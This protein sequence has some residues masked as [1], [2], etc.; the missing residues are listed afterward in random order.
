M[1]TTSQPL[2]GFGPG[3]VLPGEVLAGKY[4]VERVLGA[5][6]WG[7]VLAARN[8]Q[9]GQRVAIKLLSREKTPDARARM[10]REAQA[11][12]RIHSDHVVQVYDVGCTE[13][14]TPYIVMEYLEGQDLA[15][16]LR[17]SGAVPVALAVH[18]VL[19]ACEGLAAA[20]RHG[21]VHRDLKPA[22][23]FLERRLDGSV[24]LKLL[25]FGIA[26]MPDTA[27]L[28]E[29]GGFMGSPAYMAPEQL[30]DP[31]DVDVRTDVWGLG[32][33][34]YELLT[35]Q[36]PFIAEAPLA[37][38]TKLR[39]QPH[40]PLRSLCSDVPEAL[41]R[42]VDRCLAKSREARWQGVGPLAR[43]L[44]PFAPPQAEELIRGIERVSAGSNDQLTLGGEAPVVSRSVPGRV[45]ERAAR[46]AESDTEPSGLAAT[47]AGPR[48]LRSRLLFATLVLAALV[49]AFGALWW[50]RQVSVAAPVALSAS[51]ASPLSAAAVS[52]VAVPSVAAPAAATSTMAPTGAPELVPRKAGPHEPEAPAPEPAR[53]QRKVSSGRAVAPP[54]RAAVTAPAA[55]GSN[56]ARGATSPGAAAPPLGEGSSKTSEPPARGPLPI[57]RRGPW[58]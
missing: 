40:L 8:L 2:A 33:V 12:A 17:K 43:A 9:L 32:V 14:D 30:V 22:N 52:S 49:L 29:A 54:V 36:R 24:R 51:A 44:A 41:S 47:L 53:Q 13:S 21:I 34:L 26:K 1:S 58:E 42:V 15:A 19:Q 35:A 27:G 20:Q 46:G 37:F 11:A 10:L 31:R 16:L 50:Q 3:L 57:D 4:K 25:D 55:S 23:L 6:G 5:G 56:A 48:L 18:W 28:T 45:D 39:E 7:V 38:M